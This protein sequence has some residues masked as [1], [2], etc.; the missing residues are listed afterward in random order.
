MNTEENI[1]MKSALELA[2]QCWCDAETSGIE[3]DSRLAKA[4]AIRLA[5]KITRIKQLEKELSDVNQHRKR[6]ID[7]AMAA[8]ERV[9]ES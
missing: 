4:F 6:L 5:E 1:I 8:W 9:D 2:A 3:M 7:S